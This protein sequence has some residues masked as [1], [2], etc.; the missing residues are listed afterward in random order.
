MGDQ[1]SRAASVLEEAALQD[2]KARHRGYV[3]DPGHPDYEVARRVHNGDIDKRPAL[4]AGCTGV[5]DVMNAVKFARAHDLRVAVRAGGHHTAG[6]ATCDDGLVID[7]SP[8]KGVR[9]DPGTK[10][11]HAQAGVTWYEFDRETGVFGLA[12]PGGNISTTGIAGLTL[13]GGIGW[14]SRM[15]GL[16]CDN[17]ISAD[18][19]TAQG[20][21]LRASVSENED[22]F[23]GL[24][25]GSGNFGIATSFEFALHSVANV[26]SSYI[27]YSLDQAESLLKF[28]RDYLPGVPDNLSVLTM[29]QSAASLPFLPPEIQKSV[30]VAVEACWVGPLEEGEKVLQPLRA[31]GS[32]VADFTAPIP[33]PVLQN[34]MDVYVEPGQPN[35]YQCVYLGELSDKIIDITIDGATNMSSPLSHLHIM[36]L[37]GATSR[38]GE[39]ETAYSQRNAPYEC[40]ILPIWENPEEAEIHCD[41]GR[42]IWSQLLPH[43][44]GSGYLNRHSDLPEDGIKVA[45]GPKKYE[46]LADLK[47]KYDPTNFFRVNQNIKPTGGAAAGVS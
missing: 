9:V 35:L 30:I 8:M 1:K 34:M 33:Y 22:L 40:Y 3:I 42:D 36:Q 5:A 10:T 32:P 37:G 16:A 27:V 43:S 6:Y 26:L 38:V 29:F 23:W 12:T 21:F 11:V 28:L 20:E 18:V 17:L 47:K 14:L 39:D 46:R 2:F 13:G 19:V 31:F 15:Y 24:R 41:W 45:Y 7:L 44:L 25:G 4:I